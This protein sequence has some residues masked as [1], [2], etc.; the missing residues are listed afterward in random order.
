MKISPG[1]NVLRGLA[2]LLI[3]V[4]HANSD[5][6]PDL[7][8]AHGAAGFLLWRIRNLGW[9]GIDL[10]FVLGG[11]FMAAAVF[12][13]LHNRGRV[14]LGRYWKRRAERILPSYYFL[15]LILALT[16]TTRYTDFSNAFSSIQG[17]LTHFLFLNNYLDQLPNGPTWFLAAMVQFYILVPLTLSLLN[18]TRCIQ[19]TDKFLTITVAVVFIELAL[20]VLRVVSGTHLPNDFMLTHFRL[21]TLF[22]GMLAMYLFRNR[23]PFVARISGHPRISLLIALILIAPA[24]FFPRRD[25]FMFTVGFTLLACGYAGIIL[26]IADG[27][28]RLAARGFVILTVISGWSYNIYLWHYFL[29]SLLGTPYVQLQLFI[30]RI[31]ASVNLMIFGQILVFLA[32][33]ILAG[34]LATVLVERTAARIFSRRQGR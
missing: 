31:T 25:P 6:I 7:P 24:M 19:V 5:V 14:R 17:I 18:R 28:L 11:F 27:A 20:R 22:I 29:P 21:D 26:L 30:H 34:F 16:G 1:L 32:F 13:E 2:A 23:H 9:S 15:L 12:A 10:F 4:H 3:V 33:S 8:D